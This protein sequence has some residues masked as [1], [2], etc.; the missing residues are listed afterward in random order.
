MVTVSERW[1]FFS[2][3]DLFPAWVTFCLFTW[4][5]EV[6]SKPFLYHK[7]AL[8]CPAR[9]HRSSHS[10]P[11]FKAPIL[12]SSQK[13]SFHKWTRN[14]S[15]TTAVDLLHRYSRRFNS[16][17]IYWLDSLI[18]CLKRL[19]V[20]T[21]VQ[22][23][24]WRVPFEEQMEDG[25]HGTLFNRLSGWKVTPVHVWNSRDKRHIQTNF[26]R[27]QTQNKTMWRY[28]PHFSIQNMKKRRSLR[29]HLKG[30]FF[31]GCC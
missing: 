2:R 25:C 6:F 14:Q 17:N 24:K 23:R 21:L 9:N 20:L 22:Q 27:V 31:F 18:D 5:T 28:Q 8:W 7:S 26:T 4:V 19:A 29:T 1:Q 12:N 16:W 3:L 13:W 30:F 10:Q 11:M 15:C